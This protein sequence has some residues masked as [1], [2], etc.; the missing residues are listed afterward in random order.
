[1][2]TGIATL[3]TSSFDRAG[4]GRRLRAGTALATLLALGLLTGGATAQSLWVGGFT[5]DYG[6]DDNWDPVGTPTAAD[7]VL[8]DAT[9]AGT[10]PLEVFGGTTEEAANI[11]I[12]ANDL[13]VVGE[14]LVAND[15]DL[16]GGNI[17]V[18][19]A[20][21]LSVGGTL[22]VSGAGIVNN[23]GEIEAGTAVLS[24]AGQIFNVESFTTTGD[25]EVSGAGTRLISPGTLSAATLSNT[26]GAAAFDGGGEL[27][28][29][30]STGA[31]LSGTI[32]AE[33]SNSG[34]GLMLFVGAT[35]INGSLTNSAGNGN[36]DGTDGGVGFVAPG[37]AVTV[38]GDVTN[39]AGGLMALIN[40]EL[41]VTG[42]LTNT[43]TDSAFLSTDSSLS[44]N[45]SNEVDAR[46]VVEGALTHSGDLQNAGSFEIE[47]GGYDGDGT[48]TNLS[49]GSIEVG[50]GL[51]LTAGAIDL[52]TGSITT[53]GV[54]STLEGTSNT[55]TVAG[56]LDVATDGV[57]TDAGAVTV[58]DGGVVNFNGPGGT[59]TLNSDAGAITVE[60]GGAINLIDGGLDVTG[61]DL[62]L[63]NAGSIDIQS[64][65]M[66]IA[67]ALEN[68][69]TVDVA[70]GSTLSVADG[71][72]NA[73]DG[74]IASEGVINGDITNSAG[75]AG[76][77][78]V[79]GEVTGDVVNEGAG[80]F[81]I[82]GPLTLTG[83]VTNSAG[84]GLT[85]ASAG[86]FGM[87][88]SGA[89]ATISGPVEN[90]GGGLF[91]VGDGTL[92][93]AGT[94]RNRDA[95]SNVLVFGSGS[96]LEVGALGNE[97]GATV[98]VR[99]QG[100]LTAA[101]IANTG[102]GT[103]MAVEDQGRVEAEDLTN[104]DG[105]AI[106]VD[107]GGEV[108]L[109]GMLTNTGSG[110][111]LTIDGA[112][113]SVS[114]DSLQ[115]EA[116]AAIALTDGTLATA[117]DAFNTGGA[118]IDIVA[119]TLDVGGVFNNQS[120]VAVDTGEVAAG[121]NIN[122]T[123]SLTLGA[124]VV[125]TMGDLDS[126]G[127]LTVTG[128]GTVEAAGNVNNGGSGSLDIGA[129]TLDLGGDLNSNGTLAL[130]S[131][132]IA[133]AG[134]MALGGTTTVGGGS[135]TAGGTINHAGD[136][137]IGSGSVST[138]GDFSNSGTVTMG[139][140]T[141]AS[142]GSITNTG[143][144]ASAGG[145]MTFD[146]GGGFVGDPG[147]QIAMDNGAAGDVF[148]VIG[149]VSGTHD[150]ASEVDIGDPAAAVADRILI[151]G[152]VS[153]TQNITLSSAAGAPLNI[154]D[155][156][157][158][159][160]RA[161]GGGYDATT[162]N[163]AGLP[164]GGLLSFFLERDDNSIAL[165]GAVNPAL[166]GVAGTAAAVEGLIGTVI[167]RPSNAFAVPPVFA[168][169]DNCARGGWARVV[170]GKARGDA[171]TVAGAG[172]LTL[173]SRVEVIYRG[174]QGGFDF[175]CYNSF[176]GGW[177]IAAGLT[178]G[179]NTGS[180][181]QEVP[182]LDLGGNPTGNRASVT[183][184]D[185]EQQYLGVYVVTERDGWV[186]E[187]QLR[188]ER[189]ELTFNSIADPGF[190]PLPLTNQ[191]MRT[192][193]TTLSGSISRGF[194]LGELSVTPEVGFGLT[195]TGSGTLDFNG[196]GT[197]FTDGHTNKVVFAGAALSR[198][199][200][201]DDGLQGTFLFGT[202]TLYADLSDP[203][204]ARFVPAGGGSPSEL[205]TQEQ[206]NFGEL[207]VGVSHYRLLQTG[208]GAPLQ[209]D[210]SVRA[211]LRHS[212]RINAYGVTAQIRLQF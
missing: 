147:S 53:L 22:D 63:A 139:D 154:P 185:F 87:D 111:T 17:N 104:S 49:G 131:G 191:T 152:A 190:A 133:A 199:F 177:D 175:G 43:G 107:S 18:F 171:A 70:A 39:E 58:A 160:A 7:D 35:E 159:L 117:G 78:S 144:I 195:R 212:S 201:A 27:D 194:R 129:G 166:G 210:A 80:S 59:A 1:M 130:G 184:S 57:V 180:S 33:V 155:S 116:G 69:G 66:D 137:A 42:T 121:G 97:S 206:G 44:A 203:R 135:V 141:V 162:V 10:N 168:T 170:A 187:L 173:D 30:A 65:T 79:A 118:S 140:A 25:L 85:D 24:D 37:A 21:R 95:G 164:S 34:T 200:I 127:D 198:G 161:D 148:S 86:V 134:G 96:R 60:A 192:N 125:R 183:Y 106:S 6:N 82:N 92:Q 19:G 98:T 112:S 89:T 102:A 103:L 209:I 73:G 193:G 108:I 36:T 150:I 151:S 48:V 38:N 132:S 205:S 31:Q 146:S 211:D 119:G 153:G 8:L 62:T 74:A 101:G 110:S 2:P 124:G 122:N 172:T 14:L 9:S 67:G 90:L 45:V 20:G 128:T 109:T 4:P 169:E 189:T 50:D 178:L 186:G 13:N 114:A 16:S 61:T 143:V 176:E 167:N 72:K 51:T 84:G 23:F 55:L 88:A 207:S 41:V 28:I 113:S 32:N 165:T 77:V 83:S 15:V 93:L 142:A 145:T 71:I 105:A 75:T 204:T 91:G 94:L 126:T 46:F 52:Q 68:T 29:A 196:D 56:L 54:G 11:T 12:T 208:A 64:G 156:P 182:E 99:D 3:R 138:G 157:L 76:G 5:P 136:L 158:E 181:S 40:S 115:N 163:V 47:G 179:V 123:G 188:R 81:V 149:N 26:A 120:T 174:I 202:A 197:L 100:V